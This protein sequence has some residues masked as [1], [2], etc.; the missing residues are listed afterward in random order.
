MVECYYLVKLS[1]TP[2][3][4]GM[5]KAVLFTEGKCGNAEHQKKEVE[6]HTHTHTHTHTH[7]SIYTH[8]DPI[9]H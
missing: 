4:N 5:S 1:P 8:S 7:I 9:N 2:T 3:Q 6:F